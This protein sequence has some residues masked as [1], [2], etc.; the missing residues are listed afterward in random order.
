MKPLKRVAIS[1]IS[2]NEPKRMRRMLTIKEKIELLDLLKEGKSYA[3]VGRR[4][5]INES[6]I[7]YIKKEEIN[8]RSTATITFST[9]GKR[10]LTPRN[11]L[12]VKMEAALALWIQDCHKKNIPLDTNTKRTKAKQLYDGLAEKMKDQSDD[13]TQLSTSTGSPTKSDKF[14]ASKGW[15]DKFR[16]HYGLKSVC[17]RGEVGSADNA[18]A[19][20]YV[21][22]TFKKI[23]KEGNYL[24][25]QVFNMDETGLFWKRMPSRTFIM[26]DEAGVRGHKAQKDRVNLIMCGNAAGFMIKPGLIYKSQNPRV[27][28][29][30]NKNVLPVHWMHNPKAWVTKTHTYNW[31]HQ[32]FIPEF[33]V[34]LKERFR[35]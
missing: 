4:Y 5:G 10:V 14:T 18:E 24:P 7:R 12:I 25:E 23:M 33:R 29:N 32:C 13:E 21:N 27:L 28:K 15:F 17:L 16:N 8:I 34:Y 11:K 20:D 9:T 31:F 19:E 22:N 1:M 26:K 30:K 35:F 3:E 6:T 2:G